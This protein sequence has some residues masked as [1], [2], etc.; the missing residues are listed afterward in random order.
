MVFS[1]GQRFGTT[2]VGFYV[3]GKLI[4]CIFGKLACYVNCKLEFYVTGKLGCYDTGNYGVLKLE[5]L[6]VI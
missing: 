1:V 4:L 3:T 2:N 6:D 5:G